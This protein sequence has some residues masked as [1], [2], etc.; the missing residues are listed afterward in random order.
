[1]LAAPWAYCTV[2]VSRSVGVASSRR[3]FA[4]RGALW[5]LYTELPLPLRTPGFP[6]FSQPSSTQHPKRERERERGRE[7]EREGER[8]GERERLFLGSRF[9]CCQ[10]QRHHW[11]N[12]AQLGVDLLLKLCNL[13]GDLGC[14]L[15]WHKS[16]MPARSSEASKHTSRSQS[17]GS[18]P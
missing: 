16:C 2:I 5:C 4:A 7:R 9:A 12:L 13:R 10:G 17:K 6:A 1:M 8:E 15:V 11:S 3:R 14:R 18:R